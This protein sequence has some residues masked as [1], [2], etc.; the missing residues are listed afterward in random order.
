LLVF[1]YYFGCFSDDYAI[2]M[3]LRII[4]LMDYVGVEIG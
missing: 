4:L 3:V 2:F 1:V